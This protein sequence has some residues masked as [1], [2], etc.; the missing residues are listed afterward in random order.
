[1][2]AQWNYAGAVLLVLYNAK[3]TLSCC[4]ASHGF[5]V[6]KNETLE[7]CRTALWMVFPRCMWLKLFCT[8]AR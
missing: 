8:R 6:T 1:M 2:V 7:N 3:L 5:P 4:L